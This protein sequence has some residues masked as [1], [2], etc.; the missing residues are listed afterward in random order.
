V[1]EKER[2]FRRS[3]SV[4]HYSALFWLK[5]KLGLWKLDHLSLHK[6]T[7]AKL[8]AFWNDLELTPPVPSP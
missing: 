6:G 7:F 4:C 8:S 3:T 2:V 1:R 5:L